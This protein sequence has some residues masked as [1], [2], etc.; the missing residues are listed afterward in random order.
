MHQAAVDIVD[1]ALNAGADT[2][3]LFAEVA[4][5]A[6]HLA[7]GAGGRLHQGF[8]VLGDDF[9]GLRQALVG[10]AR[11]LVD[12]VEL[13]GQ[14]FGGLGRVRPQLS[15]TVARGGEVGDA[16]ARLG[17]QFLL[18]AREQGG[19]LLHRGDLFGEG[20][21]KLTQNLIGFVGDGADM[22][23]F[24]RHVG[25]GSRCDRYEAVGR[26]DQSVFGLFGL[27]A[28]GGGGFFDLRGAAVD[29]G[30]ELVG[31]LTDQVGRFD[32]RGFRT[33]EIGAQNIALRRER[34]RSRGDL[35]D[36]LKRKFRQAV[37]LGLQRRF[38]FF[39]ACAGLRKRVAAVLVGVEDGVAQRDQ[40]VGGELG[41]IG[42]LARFLFGLLAD[43]AHQLKV[44]ANLLAGVRHAGFRLIGGLGQVL[45]LL[46]Q[47]I[48]AGVSRRC[49]LD[50]GLVHRM[51]GSAA[52][53]LELAVGG[54]ELGDD[55]GEL[56]DDAGG[57]ALHRFP[58]L[59]RLFLHAGRD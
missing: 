48:A 53:Q 5:G 39:D 35:L 32:E 40:A 18:F 43:L 21:I 56:F 36:G 28:E 59:P 11:A 9:S 1:L 3:Q 7:L 14:F 33:A 31:F 45:S 41:R 2:L 4:G 38:D 29:R 27:G 13:A 26:L 19:A 50:R 55:A 34:L 47:G 24:I 16:F 20:L 8:H 51:D 49:E 58:Q 30:R 46:L 25:A 44:A 22:A 52:L 12:E 54:V 6:K 10:G 15:E 37:K 42:Q 57:F 23:H 17:D